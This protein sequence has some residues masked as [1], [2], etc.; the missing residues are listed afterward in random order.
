VE[1]VKGLAA[2]DERW[3]CLSGEA[4]YSKAKTRFAGRDLGAVELRSTGEPGVAVPT[5]ASWSQA[6]ACGSVL[7]NRRFGFGW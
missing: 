4:A 5:L 2:N 1:I 6:D 3:D 7:Y